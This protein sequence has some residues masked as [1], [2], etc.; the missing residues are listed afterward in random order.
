MV[1]R[2]VVLED[3]RQLVGMGAEHI[4]FGD[5]DFF[6]GIRHSLRIVEA[7]HE[8]F[9][10]LT[11]DV[12]IKV[13]HLLEHRA[14]LPTLKR[15]WCAFVVSAVEAVDDRVLAH[16]AK[17]HT[18]ADVEIAL[19][20]TAAAGLVPR[21]TFVAFTPWTT[22]DG[23]LGLLEFVERHG[24]IGH[25]DP[26]STRSGCWCRAGR[27]WSGRRAWT[28]TSGPSTRAGSRTP[29]RIRIRGWTRC[30]ERSRR[31]SS[32]RCATVTMRGRSSGGSRRRRWRR[33][34][35]LR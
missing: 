15:T 28:C 35:G 21:P 34:G 12:T 1:Q 3:V 14:E 19:G 24:L 27:A 4:T 32:G 25:V 17:G 26:L 6:N 23:Y 10:E 30:N 7:L 29:G 2:D 11:Y 31:W 33:R 16:L 20:L 5:P 22:L 8:E 18:A 9:P 13:E